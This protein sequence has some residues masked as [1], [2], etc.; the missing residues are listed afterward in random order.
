MAIDFE[1]LS[2]IAVDATSGYGSTDSYF[3]LSD[4]AFAGY[5]VIP[6]S[7][8]GV[9]LPYIARWRY[10]PDGEWETGW[11]VWTDATRRLARA[12]ADVI[13]GSSGAGA[14][15]DFTN[16][17]TVAIT[18]PPEYLQRLYSL[19]DLA[20]GTAAGART[21]LSAQEESAILSALSAAPSDDAIYAVRNGAII[22]ITNYLVGGP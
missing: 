1:V 13:D 16:A 20:T 2:N 11:G 12:D 22:D 7:M 9:K 5:Q 10:P 21:A 4:T 3:V 17:P 19:L 14:R 15:H 8:D 6:A 18:F